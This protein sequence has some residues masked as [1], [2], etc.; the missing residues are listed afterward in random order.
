MKERERERDKTERK[1]NQR[2]RENDGQ[3]NQDSVCKLIEK[4]I[5][6]K[7]VNRMIAFKF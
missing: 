7:H 1:T 6:L 5:K 4:K 2:E 3:R